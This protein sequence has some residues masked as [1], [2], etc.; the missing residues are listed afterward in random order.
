MEATNVVSFGAAFAAGLLTFLSPCILPLIPAYVSYI[1]GISL[2][3]LKESH[4]KEVQRR[5]LGYSLLFVLGFSAVFIA[6]G[7]SASY[8]GQLFLI[9]KALI[10]KIG[11]ALIIIFGLYFLGILKLDFF[12]KEKKIRFKSRRGSKLGS[13]LLGVTFA[14]A[15][16]PCVGPI[17]GSIL[18][19][20]GTGEKMAGGI[21][22]LGVYSLGIA[23]PFII[24]ALLINSFLMRYAKFNKYLSAVKIICG[25]LL[26]FIGVLLVMGRFGFV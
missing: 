15:W 10:S 9:H 11:G 13:F 24:S 5:V 16:T 26:I 19:L 6:L 2:D 4:K 18:V 14:A 12:A 7:A 21:W 23:I 17:L 25:L 8:I 1:T 22:L 20:A 3:E